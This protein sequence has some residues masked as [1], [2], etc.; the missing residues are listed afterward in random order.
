MIY[1]E[2][3]NTGIKIS[4]LGFGGMRYQE[5]K[6]DEKWYI[7]EDVALPVIEKAI[8]SGIN[9]FD[10][11]PYYNNDNSEY[12]TG[13]GLKK[14]RENVY[15]STKIPIGGDIEKASDI[16]KFIER[17]LTRLDTDYIDFYHLW[18]IDKDTFVNKIQALGILEEA[19]KCKEEGLIRHISFSTHDAPENVKYILDNGPQLESMLIQY[20]LLD[21]SNESS[22]KYAHDKGLGVIAM[23]P[24]GGGKL[25]Y[26]TELYTKITG[27]PSIATYDLA[28]KFVLSNTNISCALSGMPTMEMLE[29]NLKIATDEIALS[30]DDFSNIDK[31][32]DDLKKFSDL[33]CPGCKYCMPCPNDINIAKIF[34]LYT[35]YNVYGMTEHAKWHYAEMQKN[36]EKTFKDCLSCGICETKCPQKLS[37]MKELER[38][39]KILS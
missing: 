27:K 29:N 20:N 32:F 38:V 28:F 31:A 1:N 14:H 2:F 13:K 3:G 7:N 35:H 5:Y 30:E 10:S 12:I 8:Q 23:G 33:Y 9:Y 22:I 25:A 18:G 21:R 26:P 19:Q 16:R 34:D 6:K 36:N 39:D 4:A 15:I 11:A 37:I 24:V 17:S